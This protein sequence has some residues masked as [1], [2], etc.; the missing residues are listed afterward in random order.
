LPRFLYKTAQQVGKAKIGVEWRPE[1]RKGQKMFVDVV[2]AEIVGRDIALAEDEMVFVLLFVV[3]L[4]QCTTV[5]YIIHL[6]YPQMA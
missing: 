2:E 1:T 3:C 5:N 6:V 4:L